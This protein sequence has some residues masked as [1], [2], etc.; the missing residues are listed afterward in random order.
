MSLC[1]PSS[2]L[3]NPV[4]VIR[5]SH[6]NTVSTIRVNTVNVKHL[7]LQFVD[8]AYQSAPT[9]DVTANS[10]EN[11]D[12]ATTAAVSTVIKNE[13][14]IDVENILTVTAENNTKL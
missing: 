11:E 1:R 3:S 12:T 9:K 7:T 4:K 5:N 6:N 2:Q 10:C 8:G 14:F 13:S